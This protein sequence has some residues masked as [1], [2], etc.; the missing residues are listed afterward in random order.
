MK[1]NNRGFTLIELLVVIGIITI[2]ASAV[3]IAINP[4][5]HFRQARNA[6]RW[7]HMNASMSAVYSYV[8]AHAGAFP[9][10][11]PATGEANLSVCASDLSPR[12]I[13]ALPRDPQETDTNDIRYKIGYEIDTVTRTRRVK[14]SSNAPEAVVDNVKIVQ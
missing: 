13:S 14:I 1:K 4:G 3:I 12:F 5:E 6:T 2:L 10:C 11:I 8:V 9:P 7:S